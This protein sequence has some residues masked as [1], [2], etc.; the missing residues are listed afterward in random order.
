MPDV[1]VLQLTIQ[2]N[3]DKAARGLENF[4]DALVRVR[5][6]VGSDT[7]GLDS[8]RK[9][10]NKFSAEVAR[11]K[12]TVTVLKTI[13]E[14]S[15]AIE[16]L[17]N[18]GASINIDPTG[19][20]KKLNEIIGAGTGLKAAA[21]AMNA[22][23][24]AVAAVRNAQ[25]ESPLQ[26]EYLSGTGATKSGRLL[27]L[28]LQ[29]HGGGNGSGTTDGLETVNSTIQRTTESFERS[30]EI[31]NQTTEAQIKLND[32]GRAYAGTV[33]LFDEAEKTY[34]QMHVDLSMTTESLRK[35]IDWTQ[36]PSSGK[37]G[38]FASVAEEVEYLKH[39]IDD[40][41]VSQQQWLSI[42]EAATKQLEYGGGA[43]P[44]DELQ[45][46]KKYSEEGYYAALEAEQKYKDALVDLSGYMDEYA[47]NA[48]KVIQEN[49][50]Q[51]ESMQKVASAT[52]KA[53]D[54][55]SKSTGAVQNVL[56]GTQTASVPETVQRSPW[57]AED[58]SNLVNYYSQV[59]LLEM[60][61]QGMQASLAADIEANK[62]DSQQIADRTISI[63]N[64]KDKIEELKRS[65][66]DATESTKS[67]GFSFKDFKKNLKSAF[68]LISQ[69][70]SRLKSIIIRR[71][72]TA[73]LRKIVS[74]AKEGLQN[75][76]EYSKAV[77]TSFAPSMDS[78]ASSIATMKNALGAALAPTVQ[79]LIP[80]LQ[81]IVNWFINL[82]NYANQFFSLLRGQSSWTRAL[83]QTTT[84]FKDQTKAAKGASSAMKD[85]LADWDE[86]NI[87]QSQNS[88]GGAGSAVN[89]AV[90]YSTMFEEVYEFDDKVKNVVDYIKDHFEDIVK[91]A[92]MA[93]VLIL[94]WKIS[95][96]FGDALSSLKT[97]VAGV[98]LV[99]TGITL[100]SMA[101]ESAGMKGYYDT[102]DILTSIGGALATALGGALIG[103]MVAG[104]PGAVAGFVIGLAASI[105]VN[106]TSYSAANKLRL[107]KEKWGDSDW[108]PEQMKQFIQRQF[109]FDIES[110]IENIKL[111]AN[112]ANINKTELDTAINTFNSN[113]ELAK[114][115]A[116]IGA[117]D[118]PEAFK[119]VQESC[120]AVIDKFNSNQ[121]YKLKALQ[122]TL[123]IVPL[124]DEKGE[125]LT[126][127]FIEKIKVGEQYLQDYMKNLGKE[128]ADAYNQG[129]I[130]NWG[131]GTEEA[132]LKQL[133]RLNK[134]TQEH[135]AYINQRKVQEAK[136]FAWENLS[137]DNATEA[138][139]YY[140]EYVDSY[141][142]A[143]M[144]Y[145][146]SMYDAELDTAG[147]YA[148]I[149][150]DLEEQGI[151]KDSDEYK[152][153]EEN[154]K[155]AE[156]LANSYKDALINIDDV[157]AEDTEFAESIEKFK[158][159]WIEILRNNE[160]YDLIGNVPVGKGGGDYGKGSMEVMR[161][162]S[163]YKASVYGESIL[164]ADST[165]TTEQIMQ[166]LKD[167]FN[168]DFWN[169]PGSALSQE[170]RSTI[171]ITGTQIMTDADR[172]KFVEYLIGSFDAEFARKFIKEMM[173]ESDTRS[174]LKYATTKDMVGP[175]GKT[176]E[177]VLQNA[178]EGGLNQDEIGHILSDFEI[179]LWE[180]NNVIGEMGGLSD[181]NE[182]GYISPEQAQAAARYIAS[183]GSVS[184]VGYMPAQTYEPIGGSE[185]LEMEAQVEGGLDEQGIAAGVQIGNKDQNDIL[186]SIQRGVEA[187][188]R[189]EW[190]V[191]VSPSSN[192]GNHNAKSGQAWNM[193]TG[194]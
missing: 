77:G 80:V 164:G 176:L 168:S 97:F 87:I 47:S 70:G 118:T 85:L 51:A 96:A 130:N 9:Q 123:E 187:L 134:I 185:P 137:Y 142:Q 19:S 144:D 172:K 78:A 65:Q 17:N 181:E 59:E 116:E 151:G 34:K 81:T 127:G 46:D 154:F 160:G 8:I 146:Q 16:K 139:Q 84:A 145:L 132:Y 50:A 150:K 33:T 69:I 43:K 18:A 41:I 121:E 94:A 7:L 31:I 107:D 60:K 30:K 52:Q 140:Q 26:G 44:K 147:Y 21:S 62:L 179:T 82:L 189:K 64:L 182:E 55:M 192:W 27:P 20:L 91:L 115:K 162:A 4:A 99:I 149:L 101:G 68:P 2:D 170:I 104:V 166:E 100:S 73:A 88:G 15:K 122:T 95:N 57:T 35:A 191:N 194:G 109:T 12:N 133:E 38:V 14:F 105:I 155:N 183:A 186:N 171:G 54:A 48:K 5:H 167:V 141:K 128:I 106:I 92:K 23:A 114:F 93:G 113:Y 66:D 169:D 28:N 37:N 53:N 58:V 148:G 24:K 111:L 173:P 56:L 72:L 153:A 32:A 184:D 190:T 120:D 158:K 125:P 178:M 177:E 40:E 188:L 117:D 138:I 135:D 159:K 75:V 76:Y 108:T 126:E 165:K 90:D 25:T 119:S 3:S 112:D 10:I 1:G 86:L 174:F 98:A 45:F 136:D 143:K 163:D 6:A 29:F 39:K 71:T 152:K 180:L 49:N 110:K 103:S 193:V 74:G 157:L 161:L 61:M 156:E 175:S 83:P 89:D 67:F 36:V 63:Q 102:G 22:Y 124:K 13:S 11:A 129:V 42:N 131:E 79:A